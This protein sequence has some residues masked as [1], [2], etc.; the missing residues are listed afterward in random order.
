MFPPNDFDADDN[1]NQQVNDAAGDGEAA[2]G[3][4]EVRICA[5]ILYSFIVV[6]FELIFV[7]SGIQ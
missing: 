5:F 6:C 2:A 4:A 1:I 3:T 7:A